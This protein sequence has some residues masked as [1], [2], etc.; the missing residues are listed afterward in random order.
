MI[1]PKQ[2]DTTLHARILEYL[3]SARP[4]RQD[5]DALDAIS[6]DHIHSMTFRP[7]VEPMDAATANFLVPHD[8]GRAL[9]DHVW[10]HPSIL[11]LTLPLLAPAKSATVRLSFSIPTYLGFVIQGRQKP[12]AR[13]TADE[14]HRPPNDFLEIP[15]RETLPAEAAT[16]AYPPGVRKRSFQLNH[17]ETE[18][19]LPLD[20]DTTVQL[21]SRGDTRVLRLYDPSTQRVL[22]KE[23]P[24]E[25]WCMAVEQMETVHAE[26]RGRRQTNP[27][28]N[29][30]EYVIEVVNTTPINPED[31]RSQ[32]TWRPRTIIFPALYVTLD[33]PQPYPTHDEA[34]FLQQPETDNE[35]ERRLAAIRDQAPRSVN[36]VYTLLDTPTRRLSL[37]MTAV[38]DTPQLETRAGPAI[39]DLT[40]PAKLRNLLTGLS[41]A[42][43]QA[44]TKD[45]GLALLSKVFQVVA[46]AD[47]RVNNLYTFQWLAIKRRLELTLTGKTPGTCHLIKA[48]TGSGKTLVFMTSA[49]IHFLWRHERVVIAFPTRILNEDMYLRLT[50]FI[51]H[52]RA[53]LPSSDITGGLLIGTKD[54]LYQAIAKPQPGESMV[55]FPECPA[56]SSPRSIIATP[57]SPRI[58][59]I[60]S[61]CHHA[62]DYMFG[63]LEAADYL[64]S[65]LIATPDKL[66]YEATARPSA[67]APAMRMFGGL[68]RPCSDCGAK[69]PYWW[70]FREKCIKCN[71]TK[72][73]PITRSMIGFW[74]FDEVHSLHGIT[75]V[76][77]SAFLSA[78]QTYWLRSGD[79]NARLPPR[80]LFGFE[81]GT[82]TVANERELLTELTRLRDPRTDLVVT[83]ADSEFHDHFTLNEKRTR[84]R[85][86]VTIPIAAGY[87][88]SAARVMI[89]TRRNLLGRQDIQARLAALLGRTNDKPPYPLNLTYVRT[90]D[91][92]ESLQRE[93]R[94]RTQAILG[95][96]EF[97]PFVSGDTPHERL[98]KFYRDAQSGSITNFI[99]TVVVSLGLDIHSL[100]HMVLVSF[101]ESITEFVQIIGRTGRSQ[102][103][104]GHAHLILRADYPRDLE[105]YERFH[106]M[107]SDLRGYFDVHPMRRANQYAAHKIFPNVLRLVL[108]AYS[109]HANYYMMSVN[110]AIQRLTGD[111]NLQLQVLRDVAATLAGGPESPQ[112]KN[113]LQ[114]AYDELHNLLRGWSGSTMGGYLGAALTADELLLLSLRETDERDVRIRPAD[115]LFEQLRNQ[116]HQ[117]AGMLRE[118]T[119]TTVTEERV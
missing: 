12:R 105:A 48:P 23:S 37:A 30:A 100:N 47:T 94:T 53:L 78:L 117:A 68:Y 111:Q 60:C 113:Y 85:T 50:R 8:T 27:L 28:S 89:H 103:V 26:L 109:A 29:Q 2:K 4:H 3:Q 49:L 65:L 84:Y 18:I 44:L 95:A 87:Q 25:D 40:D 15:S 66:F 46:K 55:Q 67:E 32:A 118:E 42:A 34:Q 57:R 88:E 112:F 99:G 31:A 45:D 13:Q 24:R 9:T 62:I 6:A 10:R 52:A 63:A 108:A 71:G 96:S 107:L 38:H 119:E 22:D 20:K 81:V 73:K 79:V 69:S 115:G 19:Q 43:L 114:S 76:F 86:L 36:G 41:P 64:P 101:P 59:G 58:I 82:A 83:P 1:E 110:K 21:V 33:G 5:T 35:R 106:Y 14:K 11:R 97:V 17:R 74:I 54:P 39:S 102:V 70:D 16:A 104:P 7:H 77:L 80:P 90:K 75:G 72:L 91:V 116:A 98:A 92:G 51:H 61:Q 56:C 93:F